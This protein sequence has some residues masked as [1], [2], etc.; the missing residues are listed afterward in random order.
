MDA[1]TISR[2]TSDH[3]DWTKLASLIAQLEQT[4]WVEFQA[5]W[6]QESILL[7]A[8]INAQPVG[9]LRYVIQA[10]GVEE[11]L[12]PVQFEGAILREAKVIAFGVGPAMR[13]QG[14]GMRLQQTLIEESRQ[15]GCY[16][17]RSHSSLDNSAN[18]QPSWR[19]GSPSTLWFPQPKKMASISYCRFE[20]GV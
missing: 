16:Q 2:W 4:N 20:C 14:I 9:F 13:R 1:L 8:K 10:I 6:H 19:W 5:D 12:E 18:H 11:D 7:V 17:V 15:A 3:P